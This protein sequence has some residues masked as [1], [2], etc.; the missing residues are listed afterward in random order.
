MLGGGMRQAGYMAACGIFA[1]NEQ[2]ERLAEDHLHAKQVAS[3]LIEKSFVGHIFPVETNI[4]IF[5]VIDNYTADELVARLA[6]DDILCFA[7]SP[8]YIRFVFHLDVTAEMVQHL[9]KVINSI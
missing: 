5:E 4:I 9:I 7:I 1:I 3:V 2:V 8:N 6:S